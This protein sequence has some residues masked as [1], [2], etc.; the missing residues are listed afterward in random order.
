MEFPVSACCYYITAHSNVVLVPRPSVHAEGS[1]H[2]TNGN[3]NITPPA[4]IFINVDIGPAGSSTY[5][6][7][8]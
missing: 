4:C 3:D 6:R 2:E 8:R 5:F 7:C 1:G